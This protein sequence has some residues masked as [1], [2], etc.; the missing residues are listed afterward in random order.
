[1]DVIEQ[2]LLDDLAIASE[3]GIKPAHLLED[4]RQK[5]QLSDSS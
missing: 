2:R 5:Q 4:I 1:M 3:Y